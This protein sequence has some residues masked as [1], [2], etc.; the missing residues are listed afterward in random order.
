MAVKFL[1]GIDLYGA[2]DLNQ[3]E[4]QNAVI[5]NL[6]AAPNNTGPC[7]WANIL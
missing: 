4:L 1:T 6:A 5:Q 7:C 3:F 2:L